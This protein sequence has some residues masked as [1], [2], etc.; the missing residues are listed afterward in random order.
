MAP[1]VSAD[2][3]EDGWSDLSAGVEKLQRLLEGRN[4]TPFDSNRYIQLYTIVYNLC[5]QK[6][7]DCSEELY[8]RYQQIYRSYFEK[9]VVRSVKEKGGNAMLKELSKRWTIHKVMVRWLSRFFNYL[10]RYYIPRNNLQGLRDLGIVL[11]GYHVHCMIQQSSTD[12]ILVLLDSQRQG[13]QIDSGLVK[14]VIEIFVEVGN[15]DLTNYE[16]SFEQPFLARS[17]DFY[18]RQASLLLE[19]HSCPEYMIKA[20][21]YLTLEESTIAKYMHES[22]MNKLLICVERE[23][24]ERNHKD[25]LEKEASGLI[26]LLEND[27]RE[28][29]ARMFRL[30]KRISAGLQPVADCFR[31]HVEKEGLL[32]VGQAKIGQNAQKETGREGGKTAKVSGE[33]SWDHQFLW[34]ILA[35]FKKYSWYVEFCFS[36]HFLFSKAIKEAFEVTLNK[37]IGGC[38]SA[39]LLAN[40]CDTLL[41]KGSS[42]CDES[43]EESLDRAVKLLAFISDKDL[44][45]EFYRKK[46]SRRLL[47]DKSASD[48]NERAV[49]TRL[50]QMCGAQ[51]TSKMEGML[52]DLQLAREKQVQFEEWRNSEQPLGYDMT[53]TV[54]TTGFWPTYKQTDLAL[55]QE[56]IDGVSLFKKFYGRNIQHRK[57]GWIYSLGMCHIKANFDVKPVELILSTFQ[58]AVLM[59]FNQDLQLEFSEIKERLNLPAEDLTRLLHSLACAKYKILNKIPANRVISSGDRF[60]LNAKFTDKMRRIRIPVPPVDEKKKVLEEVDQD[61]RFSIDA[62]IVRVMKSRKT[63]QHQQLTLEVVNQVS[64]MFKADF[65][66]IKKRIEDLMSREYLERDSN[67]PNILNYLA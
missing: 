49:L 30:F 7:K 46:L 54:L 27:K 2:T 63:L 20:E 31:R 13:E 25:L 16:T 58:A 38:S 21:A 9:T 59:L 42:A 1:S 39:E 18:R 60:A 52:T 24:I 44:F 4:E 43:L 40:F 32:V 5:T 33:G 47:W 8:K 53:V 45:A 37:D 12:A 41:K 17:G 26:A 51:F 65:K 10:D 15:G 28:D 55:P 67:N 29:L 66:L 48:E 22:T 14:N 35:L 50:K 61:R 36:D 19:T 3:L 34:D 62:A 64:V 11:F 56:M 57:L 23:L 6:P